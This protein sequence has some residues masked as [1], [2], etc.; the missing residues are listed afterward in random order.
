M[1]HSTCPSNTRRGDLLANGHSLETRC[2]RTRASFSDRGHQ[3]PHLEPPGHR[4]RQFPRPEHRRPAL[5]PVPNHGACPGFTDFDGN[6][7]QLL[8][9]VPEQP[10][11]LHAHTIVHPDRV[12]SPR[13]EAGLLDAPDFLKG[14][15]RRNRE[16]AGSFLLSLQWQCDSCYCKTSGAAIVNTTPL[17]LSNP[18][19]ILAG[20]RRSLA[21]PANP[22]SHRGR[23]R[24][25]YR[26]KSARRTDRS[27][28]G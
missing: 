25:S 24:T 4:G 16:D 23:C 27:R 9:H 7:A 28:P 17:R 8:G 19:R 18:W 12:D 10:T 20:F 26:R 3:N 11:R 1:S 15:C 6:P 22:S 21:A 14:P 5:R 2:N 13:P